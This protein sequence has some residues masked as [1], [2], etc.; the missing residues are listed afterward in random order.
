MNK[1]HT[2]ADTPTICVRDAENTL[3]AKLKKMFAKVTNKVA[4]KDLLFCLI[5]M[6]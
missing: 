6:Q 5:L 1:R 2:Q 4:D 3:Q